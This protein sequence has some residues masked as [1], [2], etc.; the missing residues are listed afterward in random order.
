MLFEILKL[1]APLLPHITEELFQ[2]YYRGWSDQVS[3]HTERY[4]QGLDKGLEASFEDLDQKVQT[5]LHFIDIMRKHKAD[6]RIR[7]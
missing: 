1:I 3:I 4:P 7:L 2:T 5:L 6:H